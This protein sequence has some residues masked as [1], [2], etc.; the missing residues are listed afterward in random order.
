MAP[1]KRQKLNA[2]ARKSS[3]TSPDARPEYS[4]NLLLK[5]T[6]TRTDARP[7]CSLNILRS[8]STRAYVRP[9]FSLKVM[10]T[11]S[12]GD[13]IGPESDD[14]DCTG[15]EAKRYMSFDECIPEGSNIRRRLPGTI[16]AQMG[17]KEE[18]KSFLWC[19]RDCNT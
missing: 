19:M 15:K 5:S 16:N 1:N 2:V 14:K 11:F 17:E 4:V 13:N 3:D 10:K 8:T 12:M 18:R 9:Q 7:Q 6:A